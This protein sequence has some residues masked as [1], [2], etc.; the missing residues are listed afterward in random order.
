[1]TPDLDAE[2]SPPAPVSEKRLRA[3]TEKVERLPRTPGVYRFLDARGR[4]LYVGKAV[5]LRDRVRSYL[6]RDRGDGRFH[7]HFLMRR[8]HDLAFTVTDT[9]KEA[10]ILEDTLIK[11]HRPRYNVRLRD[12][13][14][15][16]SIRIDTRHPFPKVTIMRRPPREDA[17][18]LGPFASARA[19][20]RTVREMHQVFPLRT[21]SDGD[22]SHRTRPCL[23]H[24]IGKCLAPCV[25]L[26][27]EEDYARLVEGAVLHLRG[28]DREVLGILRERMR[29]A[30]DELRF[31]EAARIRDRIASIETTIEQ[32]KV[33]RDSAGDQDYV[34]VV[35]ER[36]A[37]EAVVLSIRGGRM[38]G[39]ESLPL[40]VQADRDE[41]IDEDPLEAFL[42]RRYGSLED[43]PDEILIP[44]E[45]ASREALEEWL[46]DRKGRKVR[47]AVPQRG[48]KARLIE[49]AEANARASLDARTD[50]AEERKALIRDA[51]KK[52][53]L[54]H[55][56]RRIE[57]VDNSTLGGQA[58]VASI[59]RFEDAEPAKDGYRR[60]RI[61]TRERPDDYGMMREVLGRRF[62][63]DRD[64]DADPDLLLVDGGKG[65][66][67]IA[68]EV[69][70]ECG[71][72]DVELAS[73]A[74]GPDR[75]F[76][77]GRSN[78]L[79]L[80]PDDPVLHLLE[81]LRDEAHR[82]AIEYHRTVRSKQR[83]RSE[84]DDVPGVGPAR[85]KALLAHF[86]SVK[87]LSGAS[88]AEIA[89]VPGIGPELAR[90]VAAHLRGK[91]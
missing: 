16:T 56:P 64:V 73:I 33:V 71:V 13:K 60:F 9:E 65:Q 76:R 20:R 81:R 49:L 70:R 11:K 61:R 75:I 14:T 53:H 91:S 59:V 23:D 46:S 36:G 62:K 66:L 54:Q 68:G 32:Q 24:Q 18:V 12:D 10:L 72:T 5:R 87:A 52:L 15:Y 44:R 42:A 1:M 19:V 47:I 37:G 40:H 34:A 90:V 43:L 28:K 30:S 82:F 86:G 41:E 78:S 8:V 55:P 50:P 79:A 38:M 2:L 26:I 3:L 4:V 58:S 31:E 89:A 21:C 35:L 88:E 6:G 83:I 22:F 85:R 7:V 74:K 67:G 80:R 29:A 84:L 57:C 39:S 77:P 48:P 27:S 69:L 25:G 45:V 63:A 51:A 17:I